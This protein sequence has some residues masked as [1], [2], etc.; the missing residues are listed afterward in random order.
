MQERETRASRPPIKERA[1]MFLLPRLMAAIA[2]ALAVAAPAARAGQPTGPADA[3]AVD[4]FEKKVRPLLVGYCY[5]CHSANTNSQG[6]L[7][8][9]DRNRLLTGVQNGP[10]VVPGQPEK[11]LLLP[12]LTHP[13][14]KQRTPRE[15][16]HLPDDQVAD[17]KTWSRDGA[18]LA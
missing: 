11:G 15:G 3:A 13:N 5:N 1:A 18:V 8:V 14:M 9:D 10:A 2:L 7:R 17:L 4:F 6:G 16:E 12:R